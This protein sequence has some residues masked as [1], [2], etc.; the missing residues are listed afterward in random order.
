MRPLRSTP[1]RSPLRPWLALAA[2]SLGG[3]ACK[4][5]LGGPPSLVIGPRLLAVRG[6][7]AEAAPN[8]PVTYDAL[9]VDVTGRL[10][11][12]TLTWSVCHI[13][14]APAEAN[15]VATGCLTVPD[16]SG[17]LFAFVS[18]MPAKACSQFGPLPPETPAGSPPLRPRDPDATGGFYQPVRVTL[19]PPSDAAVAFALERI[20]CRLS[21]ATP[22]A[23]MAFL[24]TYVAN[25]NPTVTRVA[26]DPDGAPTTVFETGQ[27]APVA[28]AVAA[29]AAVVVETSWPAEAAET[30]PVW[31]PVA[32]QLGTQHEALSALW[33]TT[34]GAFEHDSTGRGEAETEVF[35]RNTWTAPATPGTAHF[36]VVLRDSRGGVDFAEWSVDVT[37]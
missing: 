18:P 12:P 6:L 23:G 22:E 27:A 10:A 19:N 32:Q 24:K 15:A 17:P 7:P 34:D 36:W 29:G 35:T 14:K 4:P 1:S 31:D 5:D 28:G 20:K 16:D 13:P 3:V 30:F 11:A 21:N 8:E 26:L 37:P 2:L 33:F 9:A 25:K